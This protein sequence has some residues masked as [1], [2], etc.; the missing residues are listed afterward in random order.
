VVAK[1]VVTV[2]AIYSFFALV[3]AESEEDAIEKVDLDNLESPEFS[4]F[5]EP[6]MWNV[7]KTR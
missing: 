1:Y 6:D 4:H 3:D 2:N 5:M 7:E